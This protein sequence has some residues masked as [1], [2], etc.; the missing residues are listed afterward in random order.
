MNWYLIEFENAHWCGGQSHVIVCAED[1]TNAEIRASEH[2]H[3][4]QTD[5]FSDEYEEIESD[6]E[7]AYTVLSV[8]LLDENHEDWKGTVAKTVEYYGNCEIIDE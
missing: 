3:A 7:C 6:D 1:H 8:E 4:Y 2:M 5:L